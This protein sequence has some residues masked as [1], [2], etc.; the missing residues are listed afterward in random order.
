M[1]RMQNASETRAKLLDAARD[2]IRTKG[3]AGCTVVPIKHV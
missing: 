2:V 3:Y 1:A